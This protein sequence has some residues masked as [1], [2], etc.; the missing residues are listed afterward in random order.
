MSDIKVSGRYPS[1][2]RAPQLISCGSLSCPLARPRCGGTWP[3]FI[4]SLP[5]VVH[6][7]RSPGP[8]PSPPLP[9]A[10]AAAVAA[11]AAAV[12]TQAAALS[13]RPAAGGRGGG[14]GGAVVKEGAAGVTRTITLLTLM[15]NGPRGC[16]R[17]SA[18][19]CLESKSKR[20]PWVHAGPVTV[21]GR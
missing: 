17:E 11:A 20:G 5:R 7:N 15:T 14:R 8:L 3:R 9:S 10:T 1:A 13:R 2:A 16:I 21:N 19:P 12:P 4:Q 18:R 6:L